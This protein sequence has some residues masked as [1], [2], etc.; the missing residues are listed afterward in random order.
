MLRNYSYSEDNLPISDGLFARI[1]RS[2]PQEAQALAADLPAR[3]R[4]RLALFC[5]ARAHLRQVG[6]AIASACDQG[7]LTLEGG[8][9]GASLY[10]QVRDGTGEARSS[11]SSASASRAIS[12]AKPSQ[13]S[14]G[15]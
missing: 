8:L 1:L 11:A 12:L 4:A 3:T 10:A 14:L 9:S 15:G 6:Q 2:S 7:S 13:I 5:H